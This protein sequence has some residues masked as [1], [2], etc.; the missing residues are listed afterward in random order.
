MTS[1]K[2]MVEE[3][4]PMDDFDR[5][6][7]AF[8]VITIAVL[9]ALLLLHAF[10]APVIGR[11]LPSVIAILCLAIALAS[12]ELIWLR[13]RGSRLTK[14]TADIESGVSMS[15]IFILT[16]ILTY[17]TNSDESPYFILL[18]IPILR[19]AYALGLMSTIFTTVAAD[20]MIFAWLWYFF[21]LHPPARAT[22]YME[23]GILS[24]IYIQMGLLVWWLVNRLKTTQRRLSATLSELNSTRERLISKE[25]LAAVGRLASGIA[26]EV[27]NPV[28]MI[29]SSLSTASHRD[30]EGALREEMFAIAL[31]ESKRLERLT[32]DFLTYARPS[33]PRRSP[34]LMKDLLSYIANA[35]KAQADSHGVTIASDCV[36]DIPINIDVPQVEGALLNLALNAIDATPT[37]GSITLDAVLNKDEARIEIQNSGPSIPDAD[38]PQIFEP[39]FTTKPAGT[40]LGLAIA[41]GAARAHDGDLCLSRNEDGCVTFSMTLK[42]A[43]MEGA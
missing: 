1:P 27:R 13:T 38:L 5:Q 41:R 22:Q 39:F 16:A 18:A 33:L 29:L 23:A 4:F 11:P 40:G 12:A 24:I 43:A 15:T 34:V 2:A 30:T 19:S 42:H 20:G 17:L 9:A 6:R 21:K 14:R 26:H 32:A 7:P 10:F 31:R 37:G 3:K 28:A 8:S 35:T 36:E 25:K